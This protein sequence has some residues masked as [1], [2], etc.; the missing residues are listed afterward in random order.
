M[1]S[2]KHFT[3]DER[4]SLRIK[5]TEGKSLRQ[6]AKELGRNV[7]TISRELERNGKKD[8]SYNAWWGCSLYIYRRKR[9]RRQSRLQSDIELNVFT[10]CCL[11]KRWS[12]EIIA[13][14]WNESHP[15]KRVGHN[16]IYSAIKAK[17]LPGYSRKQH[18][19]RRGKRKYSKKVNTN[20]I[21]P[22]KLIR[23]WPEEIIY[24]SRIGDWEGDTVYGT[25][26]KG[27]IVTCVD[28]KSR[29]LAAA[30]LHDRSAVKTSEAIKKALLDMPVKSLS[31]D[32]GSEFADFVALGKELKATIYFADIHSPWQRGSNE[33]LNG[34]VR[35]FFPK[36]TDFHKVT[37]DE[38]D[39]VV[40]L[41]NN[42]PRKCLGWL[43]PLEFFSKCCT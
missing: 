2:Y 4:E 32:N 23:D 29:M 36:G 3:L 41:I 6:I 17:Q 39:Y 8:G 5:L 42:R 16:T 21:Q 1:R 26:G 27:L 11:D 12:P 7:S 34:L 13:A 10:C 14:K 40:S 31:F 25:I 19:R 37:Q 35:F 43:S 33:N 24:R 38:L 15:D 28:R 22:E 18:L 9:C 20:S 30:L